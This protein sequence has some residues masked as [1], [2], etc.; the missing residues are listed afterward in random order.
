MSTQFTALNDSLYDYIIDHSLREHPMLAELRAYTA[1]LPYAGMQISPDQGQFMALL[2]KLMGAKRCLELGTLT[3]YSALVMA[4]AL[5][6]GGTV[7]TCDISERDSYVAK[8]YWRRAGVADKIELRLA[9]ALDS[10]Q[11]MLEGEL[12]GAFDFAFID[13]DK[14]NYSAYFDLCLELVRPGGLVAVDNTLWSG[15]V[16]DERGEDNQTEA[17][18]ALN[19]KLATDDRI[20]LAI[21]PLADGLTLAL[22]H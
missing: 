11:S 9:P 13:A 3:G 4:L 18:K 7:V 14:A 17:I 22:K 6:E 12:A 10:L 20:D 2:L 1:T 5:P 15:R 8:E 19:D 16:L 21:L